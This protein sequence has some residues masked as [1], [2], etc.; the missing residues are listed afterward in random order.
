MIH[1]SILITATTAREIPEYIILKL[2]NQ[3]SGINGTIFHKLKR[4]NFFFST[5][6]LSPK[7]VKLRYAT[8]W[9][10]QPTHQT[11]CQHAPSHLFRHAPELLLKFNDLV[12]DQTQKGVI[13][14]KFPKHSH[15]YRLTKGKRQYL[16]G[17]EGKSVKLKARLRGQ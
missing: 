6:H 8:D 13:V 16:L 17:R 9:L 15:R 1:N 11:S 7:L 12:W 3:K 5:S 4:T 2:L 14:G 10:T